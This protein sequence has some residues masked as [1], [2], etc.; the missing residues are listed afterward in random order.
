MCKPWVA[1]FLFSFCPARVLHSLFHKQCSTLINIAIGSLSASMGEVEL[2]GRKLAGASKW[3]LYRA[4]K[5]ACCFQSDALF[6]YLTPEEHYTLWLSLRHDLSSF[7]DRR[8]LG[9]LTLHSLNRLGLSSCHNRYAG[10]CLAPYYILGILGWVSNQSC[11]FIGPLVNFPAAI[12]VS[13]AR[14]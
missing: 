11:V 4:V 14:C 13:C 8:S 7:T 2:N 1:L 9:A 6:D 3:S 12:D 5:L 10:R